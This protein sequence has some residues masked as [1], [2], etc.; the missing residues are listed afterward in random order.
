[1]DRFNSIL[2]DID[3][4]ATAHPAMDRG[5]ELA[6]TCGAKLKIVDV[7]ALPSEAGSSIPKNAEALLVS[8]R[9]AC[10]SHRAGHWASR[11]TDISRFSSA[12]HGS[13][14]VISTT[15]RRRSRGPRRTADRRRRPRRRSDT[16]GVPRLACRVTEGTGATSIDTISGTYAGSG[17]P[18]GACC[19]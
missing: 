3:S 12:R 19:D 4:M 5:V 17:G 10:P 14:T 18:A 8:E 13:R 16:R 11:L 6:R 15:A 9:R 2:G 7:L 1:M